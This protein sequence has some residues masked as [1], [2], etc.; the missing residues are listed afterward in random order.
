MGSINFSDICCT[1]SRRRTTEEEIHNQIRE[2]NLLT[3]S[4][5]FIEKTGINLVFE[6]VDVKDQP[7]KIKIIIFKIRNHL[8]YRKKECL[9]TKTLIVDLCK[10]SDFCL[11]MNECMPLFYNYELT[12]EINTNI[13][14]S[15][16]NNDSMCVICLDQNINFSLSC[17]HNFCDVCLSQWVINRRNHTCP[18]C[19]SRVL[20]DTIKYQRSS[21]M[22]DLSLKSRNSNL[23]NSGRYVD[24]LEIILI[25]S[26]KTLIHK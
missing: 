25:D 20:K 8:A 11:R 1:R 10:F 14:I 16:E 22:E 12:Q 23:A 7:K 19:R 21:I 13:S 26:V 15:I 18:L 17:G 3:N 5:P 9:M 24:E 6:L 2:I 4:R